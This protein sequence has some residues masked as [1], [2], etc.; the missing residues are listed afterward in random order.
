MLRMDRVHVIRHKV[1]I[2]GQSVRRVA[3]ELGLSRVTVKKYLSVAE[4]RRRESKPRARPVSERIGPVIEEILE[5]WA[6]RTTAKQRV[7]APR[8][9]REVLERGHA[10]GITTVKTYLAERRRKA[11]E[12]YVP[13]VYREGELAEVDFFEIVVEVLGE[14]K[15]AWKF[16]MRL[17]ASG[18]DFAWVYERCDQVSFLDGHV[19][20]FAHL[21]GVPKRIAYDNLTAAVKRRVGAVREL[22]GRFLALVSHYMF[23][24]CFARP[25]EGHDKGG[26]EAR[27][28]GIRLQ[29]LVPV[30]RGESLEAISLWLTGELEKQAER[31]TGREPSVSERFEKEKARLSPL[32][33]ASFE[34]RKTQVVEVSSRALVRVEGAEYSVPEQWARRTILGLVGPTTVTLVFQKDEVTHP[35]QRPGGRRV[36]Y[37]HYLG[38]LS[39][40]PQALR[41]VAPELT[42]ELGEPFER[43]WERLSC[44]HGELEAARLFGGVLREVR[45]RG[46][47]AVQRAVGVA[48]AS[49]RLDLLALGASPGDSGVSAVVVPQALAEIQV[50]SGSAASYDRLLGS[51]WLQ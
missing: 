19:K 40:K 7:T 5:S 31:H 46:R 21:G 4:P 48:L 17:M 33:E 49:D 27:G 16:L 42:R 14:R 8:V 12:V 44:E 25:G 28:R 24:P 2:E 13:L 35:K 6:G 10:V 37:E 9:R 36:L 3:R 45:Q 1:L 29:H 32:P 38:E 30:P 20:A 22:S 47:E 43:L 11:T 26:V 51:G 23:E 41:Q 34:A 39:R 50:E 15:K 18:K